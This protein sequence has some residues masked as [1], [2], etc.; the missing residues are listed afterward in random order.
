MWK[1]SGSLKGALFFYVSWKQ[2]K[3]NSPGRKSKVYIVRHMHTSWAVN[4]D[5][6]EQKENVIVF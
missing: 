5:D 2:A 1:A 4:P 3:I 6:T